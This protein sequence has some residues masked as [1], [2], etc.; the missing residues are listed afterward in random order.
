MFTDHVRRLHL[1]TQSAADARQLQNWLASSELAPAALPPQSIL[2]VRQL[3]AR[4]GWTSVNAAHHW[5]QATQGVLSQMLQIAAKPADG[6]VPEQAPAV[7]FA[8]TTEMLACLCRDWLAG[9]TGHW[10][11][12]ALYP[13]GVDSVRLYALLLKHCLLLPPLLQRLS[14]QPGLLQVLL[15]L[16]PV[17]HALR[18]LQALALEF[19]LPGWPDLP[20][21]LDAPR[22][23][24]RQQAL[25]T[26]PWQ[27][28][29]APAL[30]T[31]LT[32]QA[33]LLLGI[34]LLL[35]NQPQA[36]RLADCAG[37]IAAW[38]QAQ[39]LSAARREPAASHVATTF[40]PAPQPVLLRADVPALARM[41]RWPLA[42]AGHSDAHIE[43]PRPLAQEPPC[44][45]ASLLPQLL[46]APSAVAAAKSGP[47]S[48][49]RLPGTPAQI[50][51]LKIPTP[52]MPSQCLSAFG[53]VFYLLNLALSLQLYGDFTQ[54]RRPGIALPVWDWLALLGQKLLGDK[55]LSDPLWPLLAQLAGRAE[56]T[57]PGA[58][59]APPQNWQ[60]PSEWLPWQNTP[61]PAT[62]VAL[63]DW[64]DWL[65]ALIQA[66]LSDVL[67]CPPPQIAHLLCCHRA[68]LS[69]SDGRLDVTLRL[70]DLPIQV[71]IAGLDRDPGW[72]PAA[73]RAIY[74]HFQS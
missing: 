67:D 72:L 60:L 28:Q 50:A 48:T 66:R 14:S 25:P 21:Q 47:A 30:A 54:P 20:A 58:G 59:I 35:A 4:G 71:R 12:R 32:P 51:A 74:F 16:L 1:R 64:L 55:L 37:R 56:D 57:P 34:S 15:K 23:K 39:L 33:E 38:W 5:T 24:V 27:G 52:A 9:Q 73:G 26:P 13:A 44:Q 18:L 68:Q 22:G 63:N 31:G 69:V 65:L 7:L 6:V 70:D 10:W 46:Q 62:C 45:P 61:A 29:I 19:A 42:R 17:E 3:R 40:T 2:L 36:L 41:H 53:G 43:R 11:W 49:P 8:D